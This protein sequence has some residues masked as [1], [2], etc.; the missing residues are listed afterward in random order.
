MTQ[1]KRHWEQVYETRAPDEVS[2]HQAVPSLSHELVLAA[3]PD[4]EA[5]IIDVGGGASSLAALL[6]ADGYRDLTV[7]DISE[8]A[9]ERSRER[10]GARAAEIDWIAADITAWRPMRTWSVWHDRAVFH[11][12]T[13]TAQ[14]EA[15]IEALQNATRPGAI[16]I[17]AAFAPDGPQMCSGLPVQRYSPAMLAARIGS[18]FELEDERFERHLTPQGK[19]QSFAYAVLRRR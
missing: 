9:L 12:L 15:Y 6:L 7:L 2:W 3:A 5:G 11:F 1:S 14:Q 8:R 10:I 4:R 17:V 18:G 16:A 13:G 19:A